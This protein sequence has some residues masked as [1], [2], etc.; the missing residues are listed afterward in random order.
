MSFVPGTDKEVHE[1]KPLVIARG[2]GTNNGKVCCSGIGNSGQRNQDYFIFANW[3][4]ESFNLII[5]NI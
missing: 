1:W 2:D 4:K 3:M 5:L